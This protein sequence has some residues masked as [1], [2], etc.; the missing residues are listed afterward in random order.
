MAKTKDKK[1][2]AREVTVSMKIRAGSRFQMG[3][4]LDFAAQLALG[5]CEYSK[6]RHRQNRAIATIQFD[7]GKEIPAEEYTRFL[8]RRQCSVCRKI[9][10]NLYLVEY[11]TE[12]SMGWKDDYII[13]VC[14][15]CEYLLDD[16]KMTI[17]NP[18]EISFA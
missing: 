16:G 8:D 3:T 15:F 12:D 5:G 13:S 11:Q 7:G 6:N 10:S 2:V 9:D 17:L 1:R 14:F 18:K 4:T